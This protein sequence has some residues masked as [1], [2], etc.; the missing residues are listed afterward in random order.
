MENRDY[1]VL[2]SLGGS[3]APIFHGGWVAWLS[4]AGGQ[5]QTGGSM[6]REALLSVFPSWV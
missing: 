3:L 5:T 4:G 2:V 6:L 1:D